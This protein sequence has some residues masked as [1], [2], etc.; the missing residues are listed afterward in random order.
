[1]YSFFKLFFIKNDTKGEIIEYNFLFIAY[2]FLSNISVY[3]FQLN[4]YLLNIFGLKTGSPP[5]MYN[6]ISNK[7]TIENFIDKDHFRLM[8]PATKKWKDDIDVD[9]LLKKIF[10]RN[11]F[12]PNKKLSLFYPSLIAFIHYSSFAARNVNGELDFRLYDI[13]LVN[14]LASLYG[15]NKEITTLLRS[16][17]KGQLKYS[18]YNNEMYPP[19]KSSFTKKEL[20]LLNISSNDYFVMA[21]PRI[22]SHLFFLYGGTFFLRLHNNIA[23]TLYTTYTDKNDDELF[24]LARIFTLISLVSIG[25]NGFG[26]VYNDTVSNKKSFDTENLKNFPSLS[27]NGTTGITYET[28]LSYLFHEFVLDE[29]I[30]DGRNYSGTINYVQMFLNHSYDSWT[31]YILNTN[32]G[33][34]TSH[35]TPA[36]GIP[37]IKKH[38]LF[39][40]EIGLQSYNDYRAAFG[41]KRLTSIDQISTSKKN[42]LLLKEFY[43]TPDDI[44]LIVG[45][46]IEEPVIVGESGIID[47]MPLLFHKLITDGIA[48]LA[49]IIWQ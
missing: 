1:M 40:R 26:L 10:L 35:N 12:I 49:R 22:N 47:F 23:K 24:E 42:K 16:K 11:H 17:K 7:L 36:Y 28:K 19:L 39:A 4:T 5:Y 48:V 2:L 45:I 31:N 33:R 6:V 21:F 13:K 15:N 3:L 30:I 18:I 34:L 14:N 8:L 46:Y 44:D 29:Y 37:V 9:K 25:I 20:K 43:K 38:L 27:R 41:F 32:P